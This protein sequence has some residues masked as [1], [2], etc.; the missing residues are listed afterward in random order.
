MEEISNYNTNTTCHKEHQLKG[1]NLLKNYQI[2]TPKHAHLHLDI[3]NEDNFTLV[4]RASLRKTVYL[5]IAD[6]KKLCLK[7]KKQKM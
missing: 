2:V 6:K 1:S 5:D 3:L 7:R 4:I